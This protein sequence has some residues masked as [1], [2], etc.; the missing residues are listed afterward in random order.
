MLLCEGGEFIH[1]IHKDPDSPESLL[2]TAVSSPRNMRRAS[3]RR[4]QALGRQRI[5][6]RRRMSYL[7]EAEPMSHTAVIWTG[8]HFDEYVCDRYA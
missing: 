8:D 6:E 4:Y 5:S 3:L 7:K 2:R 1:R